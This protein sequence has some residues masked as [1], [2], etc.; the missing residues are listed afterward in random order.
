MDESMRRIVDSPTD[1]DM[2]GINKALSGKWNVCDIC[3]KEGSN[4][5]HCD[6]W[7]KWMRYGCG[8]NV[9]HCEACKDVAEAKSNE[10]ISANRKKAEEA[11]REMLRTVK[12][13]GQLARLRY[14]YCDDFDCSKSF[15][16]WVEGVVGEAR[17]KELLDVPCDRCGKLLG[18][19]KYTFE[20]NDGNRSLKTM[21]EIEDYCYQV[22]NRDPATEPFKDMNDWQNSEIKFQT[23]IWDYYERKGWEHGVMDDREHFNEAFNATKGP[24]CG[25]NSDWSYGY[26]IY[27]MPTKKCLGR[28][29]KRHGDWA[30][31]VQTN[32]KQLEQEMKELNERFGDDRYQ[33]EAYLPA[34]QAIEAKQQW[35]Y[36]CGKECCAK[37][38]T[39]QGTLFI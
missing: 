6:S 30:Q 5:L 37:S 32:R 12:P 4:W 16:D 31:T 14:R 35:G 23:P 8:C 3:G 20:D 22:L 11:E 29:M 33:N 7:T 13:G 28:Y 17:M 10:I 39:E 38:T 24:D 9:T 25:G 36:Y 26:Y 2:D 18:A 21:H 1:Q 19:T 34:A 15:R 27:H